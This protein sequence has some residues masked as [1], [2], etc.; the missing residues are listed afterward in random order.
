MLKSSTK[1]WLFSAI[2]IILVGGSVAY[3]LLGFL[4]P[5]GTDVAFYINANTSQVAD[6]ETAVR[7]AA[8][9][10]SQINPSGL[11]LS[12]SGSTSMTT[13]S[14][15]GLNTVCWENQG[16]ISTLATAW[17]WYSGNTILETDM[18][19]NDY[20][21]WSTSGSNYDIE[22]VAL[23]EFG[24]W[25]GL[26]HSSTGI[27]YAYYSG[28][29]RT[30][31]SDARN[32]FTAMYGGG[33]QIP[34]IELDR[35]SLS[36][37]G[38][39]EKIF[40]VRN[41]GEETLNYQISDDQTWISVSPESGSSTGEWDEITTTVDTSGLGSGNYSGTISVTSIDANNSPQ[42]LTVYLNISEEEDNPPSISI[43]SP[44]SGDVVYGSV[45][46]E[47]SA[48]DDNG[49]QK[50]E[51]YVDDELKN[52]DNSSP[53]EW[54][55]DTISYSS[56]FHTIK[57]KAYDTIN[58]TAEDS[59]SVKV[60]QPP[61]I[62]ITSPLSGS[63]VSG[64]VSVEASAT[65]DNG[66][67]KVEFYVG[68][69]LKRTDRTSPYEWVWDTSSYSSGFHTIKA[70]AYDTINQT[71][72]DSISVKVDQ[73]PEISITSPL[74]GSNV[75]G[76]VSVEVSATDDIGIKKVEFYIDGVLKKIDKKSPYDYAWDT[77]LI[78]NGGYNIKVIVYDSINQTDW[79][80]IDV[81]L[82]PH[83]PLNFSGKKHNNSSVLLEQYINVLTWQANE[84]NK[85]IEK[86]RIYQIEGGNWILLVKL[87][88]STFEYWHMNVEKDEKYIYVLKAVDNQN[89]EGEPVYLEVL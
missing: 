28:I 76:S 26:D 84:L 6:E 39:Q 19:F 46:V 30:I 11:R 58:Q 61:E 29:Q 40:N 43:T 49:I 32:G 4:W 17:I 42:N 15:N 14:Y 57:A 71:A 37:T 8:N 86:Y 82:I 41:S 50:V 77:S 45:S 22:T 9:S 89:I 3:T 10:W 24:H 68:N 18:V 70:K 7:N 2:L 1:F 35:S 33:E 53:Y 87:E 81:I 85:D 74:S 13:Y 55:W 23:H 16:A 21:N 63:N 54:T 34:S 75:S 52:T 65:D 79:D 78:F 44:Q 88:T 31:D 56:G 5:V 83:G 27:M 48:T 69:E 60:D 12:Y 73:P 38:D 20:H 36:F 62:S 72:E 47:A 64:S 80:T 59:I 66:V 51:F 25:V 67:Q